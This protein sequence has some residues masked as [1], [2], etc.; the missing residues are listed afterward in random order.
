VPTPGQ[1]REL[2]HMT[3][4]EVWCPFVPTRNMA[5][6]PAAQCHSCI[7]C[8]LY[9]VCVVCVCVV[10]VCVCGEALAAAAC[11]V[12]ALPYSSE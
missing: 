11:Q 2:A 8:L 9:A 3:N 5:V 7:Y 12:L 1:L 4:S 6:P 10:C